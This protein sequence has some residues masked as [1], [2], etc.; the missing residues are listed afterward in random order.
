[1]ISMILSTYSH[2]DQVINEKEMFCKEVVSSNE[3]N[4]NLFTQAKVFEFARTRE[5]NGGR[6]SWWRRG[7][8]PKAVADGC[9]LTSKMM[10]QHYSSSG[11]F[12][13]GFAKVVPLRLG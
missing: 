2:F 6:C 13:V 9:G 7:A 3:A 4:V 11:F 10:T 1:M 12:S 8:L 5:T